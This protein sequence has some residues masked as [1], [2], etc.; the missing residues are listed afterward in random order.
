MAI[1][2]FISDKDCQVFIDMEFAGKVTLG[3][4]LKVTLETGGYLIQVKDED[5][6]LIKEYDLEI[7]PSDNQLLQKID[8]VNNKLD[9]TIENLKNDSSLIFHCDRASF[10]QNGLYGFVDKKLN[11]IIPPIYYSVNEFADNKAFVVRDFPEGRKTTMIDSD[12]NIFFNRWFDYIGES[13]DTI[14]LGI[15]NKIIVYSKTKYDKITEYFNAGYDHK[16]PIVPVYKKVGVYNFYGYIYFDGKEAIPFIFNN[17][18]N[19]NER[20]EADVIFLGREVKINSTGYYQEREDGHYYKTSWNGDLQGLDGIFEL[21]PNP[22]S[23]DTEETCWHFV[24]I[25][26][27]YKW[28]IRVLIKKGNPQTVIKSV[29]YKCDYV[30]GGGTGYWILKQEEKV[31]VLIANV[32]TDGIEELSFDADDVVPVFDIND[33]F[34]GRTFVIKKDNKYGVY[35]MPNNLGE[36]LIPIEYD[37]IK[38]FE[39]FKFAVKKA[40]KYGVYSAGKLSDFE[41]DNVTKFISSNN[42]YS[43]LLLEK[44]G[45][46]GLLKNSSIIS[47]VFDSIDCYGDRCVVSLNGA[48]GI[49]DDNTKEILPIK[50]EKIIPL[51]NEYFK[52]KNEKGWS[53]G[54]IHHGTIYPNSFDDIILLSDNKQWLELFLVKTGENYGC[55]NN[56]G[57]LILPIKYDKIILDSSLYSPRVISILTYKDGKVGFCLISYFYSENYC[58]KRT[59]NHDFEYIYYVEPQ[60]DECVLQR[61][62]SSVLGIYYMHYAAVRKDG[63]WGI[64]DQKPRSISYMAVDDNI[65]DIYE[66]NWD[67]LNY[68]YNSLE[69]LNLDADKEFQRRYDKY[70]HSGTIGTD[71]NGNYCIVDVK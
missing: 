47:P 18:G 43:G 32:Y 61:N 56:K 36:V 54:Y 25:W 44:A 17:V 9:D 28:I 3:S 55:I 52:E 31:V 64:L 10:C 5:G 59:G 57:E 11:V 37:E 15:D 30:L 19:F 20:R 24:P 70:Y 33:R 42:E 22:C 12:G 2:K 4:M 1:V 68:R 8:G 46:Y 65:E 21:M 69:E 58:C 6:N 39:P 27:N 13:D 7:K 60:F 49:I 50:H 51:G 62:K 38:P 48:Y 40:N 66:P 29:D 45:K 53:L 34:Q 71:S 35:N 26:D 14:L 41:Y 67:D 63:K 16:Y 23:Y